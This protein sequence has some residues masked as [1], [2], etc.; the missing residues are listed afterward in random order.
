[1]NAIWT[2]ILSVFM[3]FA[4]SGEA[5]AKRLGSGGLGKTHK[6][7]PQQKQAEPSSQR[8]AQNGQ[9]NQKK[10]SKM[11]AILGGLLAGGLFAYLLGSGAFEGMQLM[12]WL[13]IGGVIL[14]LVKLL[15]KPQPQARYAHDGPDLKDATDFNHPSS[16]NNDIE[17]PEGFNRAAFLNGALD[18][19]RTLQQAWNDG[20]MSVI[21]EYMAPQLC[22]ALE[23][24]RRGLM[25][26]PRTEILD[27][28]ADIVRAGRHGQTAYI[29]VLFRGRCKDDLE[30]S[31]DGIFDVWH[32]ERAL[33]QDSAPWMVVGIE[34][35]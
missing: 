8:A 2:A 15:K 22:D 14:L 33:D 32:L 25:V 13:L 28:N 17:L 31:E 21:R 30:R 35:E 3:V 5:E 1:M 6:T 27:L 20:D 9:L 19:Y 10:Q 11:P 34:A 23:Q 4:V 29:S 18:H 26:P 24:Q 7:A 16:S 12:D